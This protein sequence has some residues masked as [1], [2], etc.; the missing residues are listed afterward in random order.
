[1]LKNILKMPIW[2]NGEVELHNS[3]PFLN[4]VQTQTLKYWDC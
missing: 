2:C 4:F 3:L 1:M